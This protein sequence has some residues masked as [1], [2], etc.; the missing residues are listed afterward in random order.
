MRVAWDNCISK[1]E[2]N[3][4][5]GHVHIYNSR[6][7]KMKN[8]QYLSVDV[9]Q[10]CSLCVCVCVYDSHTQMLR[11]LQ[12][13]YVLSKRAPLTLR[14][15][16]HNRLCVDVCSCMCVCTWGRMTLSMFLRAVSGEGGEQSGV[17]PVE[18]SPWL[19]RSASLTDTCEK[20]PSER[21]NTERYS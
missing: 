12:P 3:P 1:H 11:Q 18:S 16:Q 9:R 8:A 10:Y 21:Q 19:P 17:R 4:P 15:E 14:A 6:I 2:E 13:D 7:I 5:V 20:W